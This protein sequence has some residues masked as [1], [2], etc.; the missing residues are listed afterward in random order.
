MHYKSAHEISD[1]IRKG[2]TTSEEVTRCSLD[3]IE[4][5]DEK[6]QMGITC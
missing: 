4:K 1:M 3:R 2:E 5:N 6:L